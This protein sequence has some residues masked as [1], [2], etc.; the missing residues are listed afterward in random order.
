MCS[1]SSFAG[2]STILNTTDDLLRGILILVFVVTLWKVKDNILRA[3]GVDNPQYLLGDWRDWA[4]CWSM[5]RFEPIECW[6]WKVTDLPSANTTAENHLFCSLSIG[7]NPQMRTR[8][9]NA[10][11]SACILKE[12]LQL[13]FDPLDLSAVLIIRIHS[14]DVLGSTE[15]ARL[16]VS[17]TQINELCTAQ[18]SA[19]YRKRK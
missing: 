19:Q 15:L 7:Y 14:Q 4:T 2:V 10:A 3:V 6:I 11:G 18:K 8:V 9:R 13:N 17:C 12:K 16:D 1:F 5:L